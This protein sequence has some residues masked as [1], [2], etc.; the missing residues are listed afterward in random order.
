[1]TD[2]ATTTKDNPIRQDDSD[3]LLL[4]ST[5]GA[6]PKTVYVKDLTSNGQPKA[7]FAL[8]PGATIWKTGGVKWKFCSDDVKYGLF[9][10]FILGEGVLELSN[11]EPVQGAPVFWFSETWIPDL[12]EAHK[13][14]SCAPLFLNTTTT[15]EFV[16]KLQSGQSYDPRIVVTPLPGM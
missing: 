3:L 7:G 5:G 12:G 11:K 2:L 1:M 10:K 9:I 13:Q 4:P 14:L 16:A 6:I 15:Y 8:D